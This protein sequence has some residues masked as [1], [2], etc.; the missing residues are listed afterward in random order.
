M[1]QGFWNQ[2]VILLAPLQLATL[3]FQIVDHLLK[4]IDIS[5]FKTRLYLCLNAVF[6]HT[7]QEHSRLFT[8]WLIEVFV[9]HYRSS[10]YMPS[11]LILTVGTVVTG[12]ALVWPIINNYN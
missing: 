3:I 9:F 8:T 6:T 4:S 12:L 1:D 10:A 11:Q 5:S 2:T 7:R